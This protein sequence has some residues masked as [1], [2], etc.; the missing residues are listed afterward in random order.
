MT[1]LKGLGL[2][3]A[4]YKAYTGFENWGAKGVA[5]KI[6]TGAAALK[7]TSDGA[8]FAFELLAKSK[9][10]Q[11]LL[12]NVGAGLNTVVDGISLVQNFS[13][14][15]VL[16]GTADFASMAGGIL[17][18]VPGFQVAGTLVSLGAMGL[19]YFANERALDRAE[20][21]AEKDARAF[22]QGAGIPEKQAT[23]LADL[24]RSGHRN[25][26]GFIV[27]LAK[28]LGMPPTALFRHLAAKSPEQ[29]GALAAR[30]KNIL[31][32][33]A[34]G[35]AKSSDED[36]LR[37]GMKPMAL[38]GNLRSGPQTLESMRQWMVAEELLPK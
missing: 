27:E 17:M 35:Y 32:N 19:K 3:L 16:K 2:A 37:A 34:G 13:K 12:K 7:V 29:L 28:Y 18:V 26:G 4:A 20:G 31:P 1:S 38:L 11:Q 22:L 10:T 14:G 5:D 36:G 21:D 6:K 30:V 8:L 33:K 24:T 15:E 23:K 25:V 9:A